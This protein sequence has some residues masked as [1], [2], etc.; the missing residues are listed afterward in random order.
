MPDLGIHD[1]WYKKDDINK[2]SLHFLKIAGTTE[3]LSLTTGKTEVSHSTYVIVKIPNSGMQILLFPKSRY[4][5]IGVGCPHRRKTKKD[6][7]W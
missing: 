6:K 5:T 1:L 3:S 2:S 7:G 4:V